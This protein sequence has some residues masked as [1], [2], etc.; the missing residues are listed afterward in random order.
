MRLKRAILGEVI[1]LRN[2]LA[3]GHG[4][5]VLRHRWLCE[6]VVMSVHCICS[7]FGCSARGPTEDRAENTHC[8]VSV[9]RAVNS[10]STCGV[11]T[12]WSRVLPG[13]L[14]GRHLLKKFPTFN[15]TRTFITAFTRARFLSLY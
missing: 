10:V 3:F 4:D 11:L 15:G 2:V 7:G 5:E 6:M 1:G 13:K 8:Y 12:P 9:L 14:T